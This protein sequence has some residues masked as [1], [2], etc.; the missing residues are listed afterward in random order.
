MAVPRPA[1]AIGVDIGGTRSKLGLVDLGS[2]HVLQLQVAPTETQDSGRFL[3][4][5]QQR[6]ETLKA[7]A[8]RLGQPVQGIGIG[9]TGFVRAGGVVDTTH[10]FLA[11]M[12]DYPL[13]EL[14]GGATG[15]ACRVDNDA[16]V[17][18]LGEARY[19]AGRGFDR[20]LVL[21]LGTGLGV[22][23][24][25]G[26]RFDDPL[27][28]G[29]MAGHISVRG[30][31][32]ACYCGRVGCL[33]AL[34]SAS[35][36]VA[37]AERAGL[38]A[39]SAQAVFEAAAQGDALATGLVQTLVGDLHLGL[40]NYINLFAPDAIVLGGGLARGLGPWLVQ[41]AEPLGQPPHKRYR[42]EL[43]R[44]SLDEQAGVLGAAALWA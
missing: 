33:E 20:V 38:G 40:A 3:R 18:A 4:G 39:V 21:T 6:I 14:L 9:V 19:G 41:L 15:L 22:A 27:A 7:E 17:V 28:H 29:H 26:G 31:D 10:G 36:L 25:D 42:C 37:A 11:F 24:V 16:R 1:L 35:G 43:R 30:S 44:S 5:L 23:L 8:E 12:E 32:L 13:T 34:V 2:G